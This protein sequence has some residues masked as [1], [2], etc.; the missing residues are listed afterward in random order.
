MSY[1]EVLGRSAEYSAEDAHFACNN[2][3]FGSIDK[4]PYTNITISL[5]FLHYLPNIKYLKKWL[6]IRGIFN[7]LLCVLLAGSE[8]AGSALPIRR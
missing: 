5:P 4:L 2:G 3:V 6:N 8:H 1:L 7:Y